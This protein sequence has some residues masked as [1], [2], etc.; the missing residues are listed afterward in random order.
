MRIQRRP[1][2]SLLTAAALLMAA[3]SVGPFRLLTSSRATPKPALVLSRCDEVQDILCLLTFG[4]EPPGEMLIVLLASPGL[5]RGLE[6]VVTHKESTVSYPCEATDESTTVIYCIG[7][8]IPLG[9]SLRIEVYAT[10]ER[11]HLAGGD[12]VLAALA[13][14]TV[15]GDGASFPTVAPLMTARPTRTPM[16]G[17]TFPEPPHRVTPSP[18][19]TPLP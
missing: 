6:A 4:I 11:I 18:N 2:R 3:C 7:P 10:I 14:P 12:F 13:L 19:G 15:S 5:P 16:P 8:Q 9:S 17:P 1:I